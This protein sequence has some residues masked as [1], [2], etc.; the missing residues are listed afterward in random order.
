MWDCRVIQ[1]FQFL[2]FIL[3][4]I[5]FW[6]CWILVAAHGFLQ[7]WCLGFSLQ[8]WEHR[9]QGTWASGIAAPRLQS[10]GSVFVEHEF[11]CSAAC[12]IFPDQESNLSP[13]L[14][15][16]FLTTGPSGKSQQFYFLRIL[17]TVP[18][19]SYTGLH[20]HKQCWSVPFPPLPC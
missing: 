18:H 8:R 11:S 17:H 20:S 15:G 1:Q 13:A 5:Y 14:A 4:I 19:S 16:G 12:G 9:L 2:M 6:L 10:T 3:F 7:L